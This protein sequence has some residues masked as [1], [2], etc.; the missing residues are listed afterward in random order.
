[1][2]TQSSDMRTKSPKA[3]G[4]RQ[5]P[6]R[7]QQNPTSRGTTERGT[8]SAK[9]RAF[10]AEYLKDL[11]GTQAA[12]RAG[13]SPD[14]ARFIA[15]ELLAKP[16]IAAEVEAAM[17]ARA[18][19]NALDADAVIQRFNDIA[20][21]DPSELMEIQRA[22]CRYCYGTG[23]LYQRTPREM[24]E[25]RENWNASQAAAKK[26]DPKHRIVPF[27]E[28]GG[29][30]YDPRKTPHPNC[31][32]CWGEGVERVVLKDIRDASPQARLLFAGVKQTQRGPEIRL[33]SR[34][35]ALKAVGEHMGLF[36]QR[37]EHT[38]KDGG[39]ITTFK[40]ADLE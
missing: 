5:P 2:T 25:A 12:I 33:Y 7:T 37:I 14:S 22:C 6:R 31:P 32:E 39:P 24:R 18:E 17:K 9:Q 23:H 28:A 26:E 4:K 11:N 1:M 8:Q 27:D 16:E 38:G 15:S 30:G 19:R 21:A 34:V 10:V 40:L 35:G 36:K 29:I 3:G 13:Y 20:N